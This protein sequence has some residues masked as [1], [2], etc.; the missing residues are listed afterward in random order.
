MNKEAIGTLLAFGTAIISG[1][2]IFANKF[3]IIGLDPTVFT[4]LRAIIIGLVFLVLS[5]VFNSWGKKESKKIH[6]GYLLLIGFIG[7]GLAFLLFFSGLKITTGGRAA[8]LHKT[9]PLYVLVLAFV[10]LKEKITKKQVWAMLL[11]LV[12]IAVMTSFS[13]APS[14]FWLNPQMGDALVL[15]ATVLWAVENVLARKAMIKGEHNFVVSF[16]RMFFGAVF[17][18]GVALLSGK[19]GLIVTLT[20]MQWFYIILSTIILFGYI[21]TYY[22]SIRYINVS[23]AATTLLLSPVITL[24]LGWVFLGEPMPALQLAGS[25]LILVGAYL[26]AT[27]KSEFSRV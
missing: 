23:K 14:E 19:I 24:V 1:F 2:A 7:G 21:L 6:W 4:A 11:M 10:F 26:I 12:G 22:W 25:A 27:V 13:I 18:F 8:F 16:A 3:F 20:G 5:L 9:L 15:A 17:L